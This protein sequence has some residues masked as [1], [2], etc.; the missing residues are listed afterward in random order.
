[1]N[2]DNIEHHEKINMHTQMT[3]N[4]TIQRSALLF[5]FVKGNM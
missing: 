4:N 5:F 1:M 3:K 2:M